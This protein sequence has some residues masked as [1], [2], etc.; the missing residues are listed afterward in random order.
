MNGQILR[1]EKPND[2]RSEASIGK[3]DPSAV[4]G[5]GALIGAA[6][7]GAAI[8]V[9]LGVYG[10]IHTPTGSSIEPIP[11]TQLLLVKSSLTSVGAALAL[12]Q[13]GSALWM[14]GRLPVA[15]T[16]PRW[17]GPAHRWSGVA[18]FLVTLPVAYH[19][20]WALG[21]QA[22]TTRVVIHSILG[23]A[24][25]GAFA[26]KLLVLQTERMPRWALPVL[27]ASV[28]VLLTALWFSSALWFFTGS[29]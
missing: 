9:S 23:C 25:Y 8:A 5:V 7:V 14:Y 1:A 26:T 29:L 28:V 13:L 24:F 12:I 19:C 22:T 10:R 16:A 6:T 3:P 4:T 2:G 18:A 27:G 17:L 15:P 21:F 11:A 20:L